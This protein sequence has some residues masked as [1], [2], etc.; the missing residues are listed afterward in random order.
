MYTRRGYSIVIY[1]NKENM[2]MACMI[3]ALKSGRA[4]VPLDISFPIDRVLKSLK[5]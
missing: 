5:R 2:I 3:G 1:G 4:Y